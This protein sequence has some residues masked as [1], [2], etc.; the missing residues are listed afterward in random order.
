MTIPGAANP[1]EAT[2]GQRIIVIGPGRITW[3]ERGRI[4]RRPT[5]VRL[6]G[7]AIVVG[8]E[9]DGE[10]AGPA[11]T[12]AELLDAEPDPFEFLDD[13]V[14]AFASATVPMPTVLDALALH[15]RLDAREP[16]DTLVIVHPTWWPSAHRR[17]LA[18]A[19]RRYGSVVQLVSAAVACAADRTRRYPGESRLVVVE[20]DPLRHVETVL[21]IESF[22]P[23]VLA[24][25]IHDPGAAPA[26]ATRAG[27]SIPH[28]DSSVTAT[29]ECLLDGAAALLPGTYL[30]HPPAAWGSRGGDLP[31]ARPRPPRE[32]SP[33]RRGSF[34]LVLACALALLGGAALL[35]AVIGENDAHDLSL[36]SAPVSS[37]PATT[38][39]AEA[40]GSDHGADA[41]IGD[42]QITLP[43]GWGMG[44]SDFAD[45][46]DPGGFLAE[47][48]P[49]DH[50]DERRILIARRG[51]GSGIEQQGIAGAVT[52]LVDSD[53]QLGHA[54]VG[55]T[56]AEAAYREVLVD[57][58]GAER[59]S[60]TW[61]VV[62]VGGK[63]ANIGCESSGAAAAADSAFSECLGVVRTVR[64][65]G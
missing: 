56:G 17:A 60:V 12:E 57:A 62:L 27:P 11:P 6:R 53:P 26:R 33:A 39:A 21:D 55:E 32:S 64:H 47:L 42:L 20:H 2:P 5:M 51:P 65:V 3:R 24:T 40:P 48:L 7:S 23:R 1:N 14:L 29:D 15:A 63:Q 22:P 52:R 45:H 54:S 36:S 61:F 19:M 41:T 8:N 58:R 28:H 25:S 38:S 31:R 46:H 34:V 4:V 13:P 30:K 43:T 59:G 44:W 9:H 10:E 16:T 18:S 50:S 35:L 37:G 49:F